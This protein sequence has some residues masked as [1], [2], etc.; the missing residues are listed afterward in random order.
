VCSWFVHLQPCDY[1]ANPPLL[2]RFV[3]NLIN[4]MVIGLP[5]NKAFVPFFRATVPTHH[6]VFGMPA[7][8]R[9]NRI[10]IAFRRTREPSFRF[11]PLAPSKPRA[12]GPYAPVMI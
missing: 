1:M 6:G 10:G 9:P 4:K 2:P 5:E 11:G 12:A 3:D 8:F 7:D